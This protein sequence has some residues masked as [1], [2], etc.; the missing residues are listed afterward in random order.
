MSH[1]QYMLRKY[2]QDVSHRQCM[3]RKYVWVMITE[4]TLV[5]PKSEIE[6]FE[7]KWPQAGQM[8]AS[9]LA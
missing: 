5:P 6:R 4:A 1:R 3:L 8:L 9:A 2:V 7:C